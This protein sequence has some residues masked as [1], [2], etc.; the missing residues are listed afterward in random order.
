MHRRAGVANP[1]AAAARA[2]TAT[3][4]AA[5]RERDGSVILKYISY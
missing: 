3:A 1:R 4:A 5:V 2:D